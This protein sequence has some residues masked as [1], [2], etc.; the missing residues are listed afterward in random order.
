MV[1]D[2]LIAAA[3]ALAW[4]AAWVAYLRGYKQGYDKAS[5]F[6]PSHDTVQNLEEQ[7]A[8]FRKSALQKWLMRKR[9]STRRGRFNRVADLAWAGECREHALKRSAISPA[10]RT[11]GCGGAKVVG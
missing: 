10:A 1:E 7:L 6:L 8:E 5:R 4:V 11:D 2:V 3:F 9:N